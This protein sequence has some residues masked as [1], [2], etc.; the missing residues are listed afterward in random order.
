MLDGGIADSIPVQYALDQGYEK[1]V[2]VLTRNRGYRK[3]E[4]KMALA[5]LRNLYDEGFRI[6]EDMLEN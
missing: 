1:I 4:G 5:K 6:A 2:V 3:K